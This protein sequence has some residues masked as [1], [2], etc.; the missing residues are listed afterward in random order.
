M[1][2]QSFVDNEL[3]RYRQLLESEVGVLSHFQTCILG[4]MWP[5]THKGCVA[6]TVAV[7]AKSQA[8][9]EFCHRYEIPVKAGF[10]IN[11]YGVHNAFSMAAAWG[12]KVDE[13]TEM[14]LVNGADYQFGPWDNRDIEL[15]R[16]FVGIQQFIDR[17]SERQ[18]ARY[19]LVRDFYPGY[20][21]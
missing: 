2:T 12:L 17:A 4:G 3:A 9:K 20:L 5:A 15:P 14:W 6:D 21:K 16:A 11:L 10:S 13:F 1:M 7:V 18:R 19:E 8:A